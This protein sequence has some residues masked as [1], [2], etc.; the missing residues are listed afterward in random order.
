MDLRWILLPGLA[1]C[2]L[3]C[4]S[5]PKGKSNRM[6]DRNLIGEELAFGRRAAKFELWN[7]AIFRWEKVAK[8]EPENVQAINNLAVAYESTGN[9]DRALELYK[10]ALDLDEDSA[11]IRDNYR[12]FLSFY[13]RHKRHL[14]REKRKR[15]RQNTTKPKPDE[16]TSDNKS[17]GSR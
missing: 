16:K 1:I 2:L 14:D 15:N 13:K 3:G 7:E 17:G 8:E 9:Y 12:K 4:G 6:L 11:Q 10:L 5:P